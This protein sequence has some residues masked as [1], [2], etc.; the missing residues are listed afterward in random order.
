VIQLLNRPSVPGGQGPPVQNV[1]FQTEI[2]HMV[3]M[4]AKRLADTLEKAGLDPREIFKQTGWAR[5][6]DEMWIYNQGTPDLRLKT[7]EETSGLE[8]PTYRAP[9]RVES[10]PRNYMTS[11]FAAPGTRNPQYLTRGGSV[12]TVGLPGGSVFR[13]PTA[14][15]LFH[16][17]MM[18]PGISNIPTE[19]RFEPNADRFSGGYRPGQYTTTGAPEVDLTA[20]KPGEA[21]PEGHDLLSVARHEL[22]GHGYQDLF[23]RPMGGTAQGSG[24]ADLGIETAKRANTA[25]NRIQDMYA[26]IIQRRKQEGSSTQDLTKHVF[27]G[28]ELPRYDPWMATS[29]SARHPMPPMISIG[30]ATRACTARLWLAICR[31]AAS[32]RKAYR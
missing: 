8:S 3:P 11:D 6:T 31:S 1:G 30:S 4:L 14:G 12:E 26:D 28:R 20:P 29:A 5:D 25:K 21:A 23:N 2:S 24:M 16:H 13:P 10:Q 9:A 15:E 32:C 19:A 7:P 17:P 22:Y 27:S 18:E